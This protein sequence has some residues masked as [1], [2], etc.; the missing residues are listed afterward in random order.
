MAER[1]RLSVEGLVLEKAL[2]LLS[3]SPLC[4]RCLGRFFARLGY[5]W[6]NR[7]R[8]SA[9]KALIIMALHARIREGDE[10][11]KRVFLGIAGNM[12]AIASGLYRELTGSDLEERSCTICG[13]N[14]ERFLDDVARKAAKLLKSYDV[15]RFVV[16]VRL[17]PRL[18]DIEERLKIEHGIEYGESIK[19]EIRREVGKRV[20]KLAD[21]EV[22]FSSPE[23]TVLIE[24]PSGS[25][26]VRPASLFIRGT[27]WKRGRMISQA[28]WPSPTG[29]KYYSVEQAAWPLLR[30]ARAERVVLHAMGR[31][32]VDARMLGTGRPVV[33]ELKQPM[34]RKINLK[35]A[36][37]IINKESG[38]L[39]EFSFEEMTDRRTILLYKED[40]SSTKV[41]KALIL[42][43]KAISQEELERALEGLK[44]AVINQW[45]PKRVLHRRANTLRRRKL[46][47]IRCTTILPVLIECLIRA[48]AGLYVKEL[49][50]GD[51]GRTSPSIA[52][53]LGTDAS[54]IELD[55]VGVEPAA[56][57]LAVSTESREQ[58][59]G[60]P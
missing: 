47:E 23:A 17:D 21:V 25:V 20:Q 51:D 3:S 5:G 59:S 44:G 41:Y 50:S 34:R 22:N 8:G 37:T 39:V 14:I 30:I 2:S 53:T 58:V 55:V 24:Y 60:N 29:P 12:G 54:C 31:E 46:H 52:S 48:D 40:T 10:E 42:L 45:T 27:Y 4:D 11:A 16:G 13:G 1:T 7:L 18:R 35:E 49:V 9:I 38:S 33:V 28:Y 56:S 32:D 57:H 36:E 26:E 43:G 15:S 19:A 6:D